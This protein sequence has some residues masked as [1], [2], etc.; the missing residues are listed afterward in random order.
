MDEQHDG[1]LTADELKQGLDHA[2]AWFSLHA[3]QRM[4]LINFLL[5]SVGFVVAGYGATLRSSSDT[6]AGF[7]AVM[8]CALSLAFW[9]LDVRTRELIKAAEQPLDQLQRRLAE[10]LGVPGL[11]L[12][13]MVE[14]PR[15]GRTSYSW[16]I[17][18]LALVA[19]LAFAAGA[20]YAFWI[21]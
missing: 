17:R 19:G 16:V 21:L 9:R 2:W 4:Q 12:V 20:I 14:S 1:S 7:I 11:A 6:A 5:L 13:A 3:G 18:C 10:R 8:G 15:Q